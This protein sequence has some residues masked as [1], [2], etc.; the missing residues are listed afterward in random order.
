MLYL[1]KHFGDREDDGRKCGVCD[2]CAPENSTQFFARKPNS[3]EEHILRDVISML[4][5]V[6]SLS[7]GMLYSDSCPGSIFPRADFENLLKS[8]VKSGRIMISEHSFE[9]D[10]R[11][12]HYKRAGLTK[13]GRSMGL[14]D[15]MSLEIISSKESSNQ[16]DKRQTPKKQTSKRKTAAQSISASAENPKLYET[17][18]EWRLRMAKKRRVPAFRI[19]TNQV[20]DNLARDLPTTNDEL[21]MVHG[22]GPHF[23]QKY[24]REIIRMVEEYQQSRK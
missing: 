4:K 3:Q 19:F 18:K 13:K 21:L 9:K 16:R 14:N 7:T 1:V 8:L 17:I 23:V 15:I 12:I 2:F 20:L 24:G 10:G 6:D 22:V 5:G 11:T